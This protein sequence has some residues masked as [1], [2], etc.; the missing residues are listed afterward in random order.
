MVRRRSSSGALSAAWSRALKFGLGLMRA[1]AKPAKSAKPATRAKPVRLQVRSP[2]PAAKPRVPLQT[3]RVAPAIGEWV[4]GMAA[5]MQGVRRYRLYRPPG[6]RFSDRLPLMV[7]LHGCDQDAQEFAASTRMNALAARERFLV[8]YPE[9][10][11]LANPKGC[12]N[13]FDTSSGRAFSEAALIMSAIDQ[14][15]VLYPV[16]RT[17]VTVAG[18]SAGASMAALLATRY[19]HRFSGVVM[20]SGIPPGAARSAVSA[21]AAMH[22]LRSM[23]PGVPAPAA[24]ARAWPPLMV[25]HGRNDK[26]VAASNG[27]AAVKAWAVAAGATA[28]ATRTIQRGK[29]YPAQVTDFK[30]RGTRVATLVDIPGLGHAWSGGSPSQAYGDAQGPDASRLIWAFAARQERVIG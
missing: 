18:L 5:G 26:V 28:G 23:R 9:Q 17:R 1:A 22:G 25:I 2:R 3:P 24:S 29:R 13:W 6:V 20:H 10:D 7:M 15:S 12:W 4:S 21:V 27:H 30:R 14:V 11:R 16:D 19:P 8:L